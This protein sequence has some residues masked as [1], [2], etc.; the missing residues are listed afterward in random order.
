MG[1]TVP[2]SAAH[3]GLLLLAAPSG[4]GG[5][6]LDVGASPPHPQLQGEVVSGQSRH[7]RV[8]HHGHVVGAVEGEDQGRIR[9]G[10][11]GQGRGPVGGGGGRW[12]EVDLTPHST[13]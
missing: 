2:D 3:D 10:Q 6:G 1:R 7:H 8:G 5:G 11:S 13:W 12:E 4:L 9:G